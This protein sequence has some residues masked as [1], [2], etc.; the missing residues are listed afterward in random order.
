MLN[1]KSNYR[2]QRGTTHWCPPHLTG[3]RTLPG[4]Q[5]IQSLCYRLSLDL[6]KR[7]SCLGPLLVGTTNIKT[8]SGWLVLQESVFI[9]WYPL[10]QMDVVDKSRESWTGLPGRRARRWEP[11]CGGGGGKQTKGG[12][13]WEA[14][15]SVGALHRAACS[16]S[17]RP[18]SPDDLVCPSPCLDCVVREVRRQQRGP[19][20]PGSLGSLPWPGFGR[21]QSPEEPRPLAL[22]LPCPVPVS[23]Y[24]TEAHSGQR[25][26]A[27]LLQLPGW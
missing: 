25:G 1:R 11:S 17:P 24:P 23:P 2:H 26:A 18:A 6:G 21:V 22:S 7:V 4:L 10:E 14:R 8:F 27:R 19:C 20:A 5:P 16:R 12:P 13:A 15:G 3:R 9:A